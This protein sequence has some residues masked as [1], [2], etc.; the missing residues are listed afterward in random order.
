MFSLILVF[1]FIAEVCLFFFC[2]SIPNCLSPLIQRPVSK[3]FSYQ[4]HAQSRLL[5]I[6]F[7]QFFLDLSLISKV[8]IAPLHSI[9]AI[10]FVLGIASIL[11]LSK[12][13]LIVNDMYKK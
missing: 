11:Q 9:L 10:F 3:I 2:V 12:W 4:L 1:W 7:T 13:L 5:A 6:L 8:N